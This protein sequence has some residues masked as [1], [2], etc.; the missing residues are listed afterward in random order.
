MSESD[1]LAAIRE[2]SEIRRAVEMNG[3]KKPQRSAIQVF[4]LA[5]GLLA[6]LALL[7]LELFR[8]IGPTQ[9]LIETHYREKLRYIAILDI[10]GC[11]AILV[12]GLSFLFLLKAREQGESFEAYLAR[13]FSFLSFFALL[14]DL[15]TKFA[16][17]S[18]LIL[19]GRPD[20]VAPMFLVFLGD[21][22]IQGR[23]FVLPLRVASLLGMCAI[24]LGV[25]QCL[26]WYGSLILPFSVFIFLSSASLLF[27]WHRSRTGIEE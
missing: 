13:S 25:L 6:V 3:A 27:L 20:W 24:G 4:L 12:C 18:L 9:F 16:A 1:V 21:Y 17:V 10:G 26:L 8:P 11:L 22:L 14:S 23:Y 15:F 5:T 2:L 19:A 7:F